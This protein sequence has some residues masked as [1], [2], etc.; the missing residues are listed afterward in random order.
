MMY[1][2]RRQGLINPGV[3]ASVA[4]GLCCLYFVSP[5]NYIIPIKLIGNRTRTTGTM[6]LYFK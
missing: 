1:T 6:C 3:S 2:T 4:D 5:L